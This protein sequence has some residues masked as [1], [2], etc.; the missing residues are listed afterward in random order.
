M[1]SRIN[2]TQ[3]LAKKSGSYEVNSS[4]DNAGDSCA[5]S[6]FSIRKHLHDDPNNNNININNN[7]RKSPISF[8]R[9][10]CNKSADSYRLKSGSSQTNAQ[11]SPPQ[12]PPPT[13]GQDGVT[14]CT[15]GAGTTFGASAMPG[16]A[17]SVSVV[18]SD[19]CTLLGVRRADFQEIFNEPALKVLS[20]MAP[21][22]CFR[23]ILSKRAQERSQEEV[24]MVFEELQHLK[25]LSH[26]TNSVKKEL[27][28]CV[29]SEHHALQNT[30]I[31]NQGDPGHSWYII[32]QGSVNVVIVGKGVVCSLHEG[33]D[34]GKL[35]LVNDA[36]RAATIVTNE[37]NCYFLRVDKHN[38]NTI[39]RDV[40]ANTVRLKEHGEYHRH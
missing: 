31:F 36:P 8:A 32:L 28:G 10:T 12:Q 38:F 37:P 19:D 24:D 9:L 34:F 4:V 35:A 5:I 14:L 30:V 29:A 15:L 23:L 18:T 20:K 3:L 16:K 17:H 7:H 2:I 21:D 6:G 22:A 25:A 26:L 27:A 11:H 39:L 13:P 40:E 33:D 1:L